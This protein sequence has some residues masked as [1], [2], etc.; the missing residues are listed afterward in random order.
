MIFSWAA[1]PQPLMGFKMKIVRTLFTIAFIGVISSLSSSKSNSSSSS[2]SSFSSSSRSPMSQNKNT[3]LN[4]AGRLQGDQPVSLVGQ[5]SRTTSVPTLHRQ[6]WFTLAHYR[7]VSDFPWCVRRPFVR[8]FARWTCGARAEWQGGKWAKSTLFFEVS[9]SSSPTILRRSWARATSTENSRFSVHQ[10]GDLFQL[11]QHVTLEVP[12]VTELHERIVKPGVLLQLFSGPTFLFPRTRRSSVGLAC[13]HWCWL[14]V[15]FQRQRKSKTN[16]IT[17]PELKVYTH[18]C[19][20][21]FDV[22]AWWWSRC[23]WHRGNYVSLVWG[24]T[25]SEAT[26]CG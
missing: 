5:D 9:F 7:K 15:S 16:E 18:I 20:S 26:W 11:L 12:V 21:G 24:C 4:P 22:D 13:L 23:Q 10:A 3:I 2:S 1:A 25:A 6:L 17:E 8:W 14:H 19:C